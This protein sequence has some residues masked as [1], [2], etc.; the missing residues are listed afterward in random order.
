MRPVIVNYRVE[1]AKIRRERDGYRI[2]V[3]ADLHNKS[4]GKDNQRLKELLTEESPDLIL[5]AGDMITE[6]AGSAYFDEAEKLLIDLAEKF[7]LYYAKGNHEERW[8]KRG[9]SPEDFWAFQERLKKRG[10]HFLENESEMENS[11]MRIT[12]LELPLSY[13]HRGRFPRLTEEDITSLVG[14]S[15]S[16]HFQVLLAHCPQFFLSYMDWG[17][18]LVLSGHFHGGLI[19]L[20]F[21]GGVISPYLRLF[22]RYDRGQFLGLKGQMIV[23]GGLGSHTLPIRVGNPEELV[24]LELHSL[25]AAKEETD[26]S[27]GKT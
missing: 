21:L 6:K 1:H 25:S 17:A 26:G 12:G 9:K 15:D 19:R 8:K 5:I 16:L 18:D 22:P 11:W 2:A 7:P 27:G 20:P 23:S 10:V 3:M 24:M 13:F 14:S 4:W